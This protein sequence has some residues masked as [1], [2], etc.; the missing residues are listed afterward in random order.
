L[1]QALVKKYNKVHRSV[2]ASIQEGIGM[3]FEVEFPPTPVNQ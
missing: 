1:F 3:H 2:C